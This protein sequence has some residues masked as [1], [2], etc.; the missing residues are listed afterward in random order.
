MCKPKLY[1]ADFSTF[2]DYCKEKWGWTRRYSDN[3]IEAAGVVASLPKNENHGSQ[4]T[5][6]RQAREL[7][8][9]EP[10]RR[11]EVL[12]RTAASKFPIVSRI[13]SRSEKNGVNWRGVI[14]HGTKHEPDYQVDMT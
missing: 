10:V 3:L 7:A 13:V 1:R 11:V 14:R 6:E 12:E 2:E 9:V 5:N 4:I 8:K